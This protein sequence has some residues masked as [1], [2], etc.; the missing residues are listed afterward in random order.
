ML[1]VEGGRERGPESV[2]LPRRDAE[3]RDP[4]TPQLELPGLNLEKSKIALANAVATAVAD[5]WIEMVGQDRH[6]GQASSLQEAGRA[7]P[8]PATQANPRPYPADRAL[9]ATPRVLR[10]PDG[11]RFASGILLAPRTSSEGAEW[12]TDLNRVP[13]CRRRTQPRGSPTASS[14]VLSASR[15]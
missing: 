9:A 10:S 11:R 13:M 7:Y 3:G 12:L 1:T 15:P 2:I 4:A 8:V 14:R 6:R 5:G